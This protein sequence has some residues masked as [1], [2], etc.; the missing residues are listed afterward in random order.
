[1]DYWRL[2]RDDAYNGSCSVH[3][4]ELTED[5]AQEYGEG[6]ARGAHMRDVAAREGGQG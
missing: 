2:G 1:M 6:Y 4:Q 5:E 3:G